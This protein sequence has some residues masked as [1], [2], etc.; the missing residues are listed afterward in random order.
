MKHFC[1]SK[2]FQEFTRWLD[3]EQTITVKKN[4]TAD[5]DRVRDASVHEGGQSWRG[6]RQMC[7]RLVILSGQFLTPHPLKQTIHSA[8]DRSTDLNRTARFPSLFFFVCF[9]L[10]CFV[11]TPNE[12]SEVENNEHVLCS[13]I[14]KGHSPS[15]A[16]TGTCACACTSFCLL[17]LAFQ[18]LR[19]QN[20]IMFLFMINS[21]R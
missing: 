5:A 13:I 18:E 19:K 14:P 2:Q 12:K 21:H 7:I 9:C 10:F 6:R 15:K 16:I 20:T 11:P 4:R 17:F 1:G 8:S 3:D